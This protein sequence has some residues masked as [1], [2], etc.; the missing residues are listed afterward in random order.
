MSDTLPSH[1]SRVLKIGLLLVTA[2][3]ANAAAIISPVDEFDAVGP[4]PAGWERDLALDISANPNNQTASVIVSP[5][6]AGYLVVSLGPGVEGEI[7]VSY[8]AASGTVNLT[9]AGANALS[10]GLMF[11]D[12]PGNFAATVR[13]MS[14]NVA[15][16]NQA[17]SSPIHSATD[18]LLN[19]A[20]FSNAGNTDFSNATELS[21]AFQPASP[22]ADV[23]IDYFATAVSAVPEPSTGAL[24]LLA[25]VLLLRRQ[26]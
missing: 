2:S 26:R 13:D 6:S 18:L 22:G 25:G 15:T 3:V 11:G 14:G 5:A 16:A 9:E 8:S 19:Y 21:I 4:A 10:I 23:V 17:F 20:D 24:I 7:G 12:I 1:L